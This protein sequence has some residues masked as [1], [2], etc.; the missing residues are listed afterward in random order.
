M[1]M[2]KTHFSQ[3]V[4]IDGDKTQLW[5]VTLKEGGY[6]CQ[7]W[8]LDDAQLDELDKPIADKARPAFLDK[9]DHVA[10]FAELGPARDFFEGAGE[11]TL[12]LQA[13]R[14]FDA[15]SADS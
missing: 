10:T 9:P 1:A 5:T 13:K 11:P 8:L 15:I 2:G 4:P 14:F 7:V 6:I 3:V 12:V